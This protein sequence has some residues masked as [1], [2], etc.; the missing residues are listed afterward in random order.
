VTD[1]TDRKSTELETIPSG[2]DPS[3]F[4]AIWRKIWQEKIAL[5]E[6]KITELKAA[7]SCPAPHEYDA[8]A[9]ENFGRACEALEAI[10]STPLFLR[11][12]VTDRETV[13]RLTTGLHELVLE[14][15]SIGWNVIDRKN[16]ERLA[17]LLDLPEE[18]R[19][20]LVRIVRSRQWERSWQQSN[21]D[22][23]ELPSKARTELARVHKLADHLSERLRK[24]GS[25]ARYALNIALSEERKATQGTVLTPKEN[26]VVYAHVDGRGE[27]G[28]AADVQRYESLGDADER[29]NFWSL[30]DE[31]FELDVITLEGWRDRFDKAVKIA[32]GWHKKAGPD[33]SL[34]ELVERLHEFL[35]CHTGKGLV[36]ASM[37]TKTRKGRAK[38][39]ADFVLTITRMIFGDVREDTIDDAVKDVI[40]RHRFVG[41]S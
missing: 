13:E 8:S 39:C 3:E 32:S 40:T 36:R 25:G 26:R 6:Q 23:L 14:P 17:R 12:N 7:A 35:L 9:A 27:A 11:M 33:R 28:D 18:A 29:I 41:K 31:Q 22:D 4:S 5:L 34:R 37:R 24:L 15:S 20:D 30:E 10:G 38:A 21:G 2:P 16:W 1:N 19:I